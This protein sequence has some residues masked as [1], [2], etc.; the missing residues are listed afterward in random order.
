ML[1]HYIKR[2]YQLDFLPLFDSGEMDSLA[3][4]GYTGPVGDFTHYPL[5]WGVQRAVHLNFNNAIAPF[6]SK[7][8]IFITRHPLDVLVSSF[9]HAKRKVPNVAYAGSLNDFVYD[10]VYG[11]DKLLAFHQIWAKN[12]DKVERFLLWRYE[13]LRA[14][15]EVQLRKLL[16]F[17][18]VES[19]DEAVTDA[20]KYASF[21]NLKAMESAGE[22]L[23][24]ASSGF[25]AF[26]DGP[27]DDPNAFHIRKG[28]VGGYRDELAPDVVAHLE[29]RV[30]AEMPEMFGYR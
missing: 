26:G 2:V 19:Q 20:V 16:A 14:E 27:K 7:R 17:L 23:V 28:L 18:D 22:R 15:P 29:A 1:G 13:D 10:S 3:S 25:N 21:E 11:I 4:Q 8:V 30:C 6:M 9:M 12:H 5:E 24:Y